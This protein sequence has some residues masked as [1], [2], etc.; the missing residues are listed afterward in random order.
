MKELELRLDG[1]R[2]DLEPPVRLAGGE[3][4]VPVRGFSQAV[5]AE[6]EELDDGRL[7]VCRGEL[8][9]P[10][11]GT[12]LIEIEGEAYAPLEELAEVLGLDWRVAGEILRVSRAGDE[13]IGLE[14]GQAA[15]GFTLP[16]LHTGE[17]V[18]AD[19]FR[20]KKAIFYMWAS[21]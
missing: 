9:M 21:W 8:C 14:V 2:V 11:A 13:R 5:G 12:E 4:L 7:A 20:G 1:A 10:L 17:P 3:L 6:V 15:P 19:D 18:S 16:D